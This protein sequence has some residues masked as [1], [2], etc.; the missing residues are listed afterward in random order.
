[1]NLCNM[2]NSV[3]ILYTKSTHENMLCFYTL[4]MFNLKKK[5]ENNHVNSI[6][7]NKIEVPLVGQ[8]KQI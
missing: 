2:L 1:M 5:Q 7:N 8:Q 6:K 3:H 4:A